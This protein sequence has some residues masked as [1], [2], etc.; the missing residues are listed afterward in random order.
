[1]VSQFQSLKLKLL[2]VGYAKLDHNWNFDHVIS[3]FVRL[4]LI[5]SGDALVYHSGK[6]LHLVPGNMYLIPS[7]TY[8]SYKCNLSHEQ[9]YI[10]FFEEL[11]SGLSVFD[12]ADFKHEVRATKLDTTYFERLLELNPNRALFDDDPDKYDNLPVL[13]E[14]EKK[15]SSLSPS[16]FIETNGIL[17]LL[18]AKFLN[19]I[20][21]IRKRNTSN[22]NGV[23]HYISEN[24]NKTL[25]VKELAG[26]CHLSTDHF[27]R[28][29][30]EGFGVRPSKYI[31]YKRIERALFLLVTTKYP[32]KEISN[33]I[34]FEDYTYFSR[35]FKQHVGK[36]PREFRQE[37]VNV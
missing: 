32:L 15:N 21:T 28:S 34:G 37:K 27:S 25:T 4:Y 31:Q 8:S 20:K 35:V 7:Y 5:T 12:F 23:M 24:L 18:F 1:M 33:T 6:K 9:Y 36:T 11:G 26:F 10:S 13:L 16:Q 17:K 22:L 19:S 2:N 30:K 29:F 3:P 14:F